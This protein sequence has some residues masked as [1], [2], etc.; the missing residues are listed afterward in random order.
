MSDALREIGMRKAFKFAVG[1]LQNSL[2]RCGL[3]P[4]PLRRLLLCVFGAKIGRET[5]I[6]ACTFF[7]LYRRGLKG[8]ALGHHCFVAEECLFDCADEIHCG[9]HVT[10]AERVTILTHT[11]VGFHSHPLQKD[12]P[13][14]HAPVHIGSGCFIGTNATILPGVTL[15]ERVMVGACSL[16]LE[17][18]PAGDVV[19]GV[20]ARSVRRERD[21]H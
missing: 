13:S 18:V 15:G 21:S 3:T 8:F 6:H 2:L 12:F 20:P 4:P 9:D 14:M 10:L 16:V 5:I 11:N 19:A 17:D 7:N 1:Q